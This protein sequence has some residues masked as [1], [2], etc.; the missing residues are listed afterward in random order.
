MRDRLSIGFLL[1]VLGVGFFMQQAGMI[2]FSE[3]IKI[4]WPLIFVI[5]GFLELFSKNN[6]SIIVPIIFIVVGL[7]LIINKYFELNISSYIWPIILITVGLVVIFSRRGHLAIDRPY[8][9]TEAGKDIDAIAVF[10]GTEIRSESEDFKG[11]TVKTV[12]GGIEIDLR[13]AQIGEDGA[14]I[15]V[16]SVFGGVEIIVPENIHIEFSGTPIF[17]GWENKTRRR[18]NTTDYKTLHIHGT[19]IFSGI[20]VRD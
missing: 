8:Q 11:G 14:L 3:I 20:E 16:I 18:S 12:F 10:S 17:G 2:N 19:V 7:L 9:I 13:N 6:S 5:I 15:E 1:I 4:W